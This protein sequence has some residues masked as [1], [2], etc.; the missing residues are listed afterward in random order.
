MIYSWREASKCT[1]GTNSFDTINTNSNEKP[2]NQHSNLNEEETHNDDTLLNTSSN[3]ALST[4]GA[5]Q[6]LL[7]LNCEKNLIFISS[8]HFGQRSPKR[9]NNN[10]FNYKNSNSTFDINAG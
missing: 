8:S 6:N 3:G 1:T 10:L 7:E 4:G 2:V 9:N 5:S